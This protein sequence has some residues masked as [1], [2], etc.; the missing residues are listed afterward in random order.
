MGLI[1]ILVWNEILVAVI[2][3]A[4]SMG[5]ARIHCAIAVAASK[6]ADGTRE[7]YLRENCF[8]RGPFYCS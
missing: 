2:S 7:N 8:A 5:N 3:I 4:C 1:I 6:L